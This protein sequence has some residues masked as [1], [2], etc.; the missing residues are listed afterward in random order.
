MACFSSAMN[1]KRIMK[2]INTRVHGIL[3]YS[4]GVLLV[5]APWLFGFAYGGAETWV[6]V[7]IGLSTI[8]FSLFTNYELGAV[9]TISMPAHLNLD[10]AAGIFLALSPWILNFDDRVYLP[11]LIIGLA[12]VATVILSSKIPYQNRPA[13]QTKEAGRPAHLAHV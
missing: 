3:D 2:I 9:K 7:I 8:L 1:K 10:L 5:A 4:L 11:H 12:E 6:P 13:Q